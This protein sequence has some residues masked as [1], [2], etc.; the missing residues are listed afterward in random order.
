MI[1]IIKKIKNDI[2]NR[3]RIESIERVNLKFFFLGNRSQYKISSTLHVVTVFFSLVLSPITLSLSLKIVSG[4]KSLTC[5][6][7]CNIVFLLGDLDKPFGIFDTLTYG[8]KSIIESMRIR[9]EYRKV[10]YH[11]ALEIRGN[12]AD[13]AGDET[14]GKSEEDEEPGNRIG[15]NSWV[16]MTPSVAI[17]SDNEATGSN[18]VN[19]A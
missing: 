10:A 13:V 6:C 14:V 18:G 7:R 15:R 17:K 5:F 2:F 4:I 16:M 1:P 3:D 11:K 9:A 19:S 12:V 8:W